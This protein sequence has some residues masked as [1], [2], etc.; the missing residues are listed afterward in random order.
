MVNDIVHYYTLNVLYPFT[1]LT[2]LDTV[3]SYIL[4]LDTV[5]FS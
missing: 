3:Y 5:L 1:I 2:F 4:Q